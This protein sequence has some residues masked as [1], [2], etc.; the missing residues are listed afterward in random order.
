MTISNFEWWWNTLHNNLK[1]S[2][3]VFNNTKMMQYEL[4]ELGQSE[5]INLSRYNL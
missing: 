5:S 3:A 2:D 1:R 4:K